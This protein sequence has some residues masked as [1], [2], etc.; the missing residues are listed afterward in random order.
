L[1][2]FAWQRLPPNLEFMPVR[3]ANRIW[4][5][6][7]LAALTGGCATHNH[8]ATPTVLPADGKSSAAFSHA[9]QTIKHLFPPAYRATQRAIVTAG[10]KQFTCDGLLQVSP[11]GGHHLAIVSSF[12]V[13]TDLRVQPDGRVELLKVTPLFRE[14]WSRRFVARDLRRLF[15][16]PANLQPAGRLAAG[17]VVLQAVPA[18]DGVTADYIFSADG[19][20]W[21]EL[22]LMQ[23]GKTFYRA[24]PKNFRRFTGVAAEMPSSFEVSAEA[25]RLELRIADLT[26]PKPEVS[27]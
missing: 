16:T 11:D 12:G 19:D 3:M 8:F 13:V 15:I 25:Y 26:V 18:A 14:D 20:R 27:P 22:D 2:K 17:S 10:G 23:N 1:N 6:A 5:T 4:F 9:E 24:V 7:L 21:Q